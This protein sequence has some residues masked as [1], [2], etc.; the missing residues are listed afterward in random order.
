MM[1]L[2]HWL[3]RLKNWR[4][5]TNIYKG[6]IVSLINSELLQNNES[7]ISVINNNDLLSHNRKRHVINDVIKKVTY[8]CF[9]TLRY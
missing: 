9:F 8:F 7:S 4:F 1:L 5:P 3:F 2:S 6:F